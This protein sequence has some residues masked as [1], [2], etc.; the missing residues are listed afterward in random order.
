MADWIDE[1][2]RACVGSLRLVREALKEAD[3]R[4]AARMQ[5]AFSRAV[6]SLRSFD[7]KLADHIESL[8]RES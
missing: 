2:A 3:R 6:S 7:P 5:T 8:A 1:R 4:G